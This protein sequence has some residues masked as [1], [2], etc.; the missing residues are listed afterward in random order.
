MSVIEPIHALMFS[1]VSV[2]AVV[3]TD[4]RR[5]SRG[6]ERRARAEPQSGDRRE[7]AEL[8]LPAH[9]AARHQPH[10]LPAHG[11]HTQTHLTHYQ[12]RPTDISQKGIMGNVEMFKKLRH[13]R[14]SQYSSTLVSPLCWCRFGSHAAV[15]SLTFQLFKSF[16]S[17]FFQIGRDSVEG[18]NLAVGGCGCCWYETLH[19]SV[20]TLAGI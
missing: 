18:V 10:E 7:A 6:G 8:H 13:W 3:S 15:W 9:L 16:E 2:S 5:R 20:E 17:C 14:M 11:K 4:V 19:I 12:R 1:P